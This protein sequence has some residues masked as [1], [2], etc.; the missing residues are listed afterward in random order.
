VP[1]ELVF[2]ASAVP[3][4]SGASEAAIGSAVPGFDL[5]STGLQGCIT[6][7]YI[8][9]HVVAQHHS[10]YLLGACRMFIVLS[11][12][13]QLGSKIDYC[14]GIGNTVCS[15]LRSMRNGPL[16]TPRIG[17]CACLHS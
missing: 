15:S 17:R 2:V 6:A 14:I 3:R 12:S 9:G 1:A 5:A 16:G 4:S 10:P 11:H 13:A 7:T 8:F